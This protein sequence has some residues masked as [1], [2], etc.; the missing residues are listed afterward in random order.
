MKLL[1]MFGP[2]KLGQ[3]S[4]ILYIGVCFDGGNDVTDRGF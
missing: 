3:D 4:S 1:A 2:S